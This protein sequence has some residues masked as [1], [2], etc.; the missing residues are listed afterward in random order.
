ML[1]YSMYEGVMIPDESI[2]Y[3]GSIEQKSKVIYYKLDVA[4]DD[5]EFLPPLF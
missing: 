2:V 3:Q 4:L 1:N 5:K